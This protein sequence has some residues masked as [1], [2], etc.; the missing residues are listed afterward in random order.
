MSAED[1]ET[2]Y[3]AANGNIIKRV[4]LNQ[5]RR[6][7]PEND[8][9]SSTD[10]PTLWAPG[11]DNKIVLWPKTFAA[12]TLRIDGKI[13]PVAMT[14]LSDFPTIPYRYQES[15]IEYVLAMALDR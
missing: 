13:T 8:D 12:G 3:D 15:F 5:L 11:G 2:I 10:T 4:D 1:V 14:N 9:G 7:D 6:L